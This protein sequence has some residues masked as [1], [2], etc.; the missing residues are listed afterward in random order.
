MPRHDH[1]CR[2]CRAE[3]EVTTAEPSACTVCGSTDTHWR[4]KLGNTG[5]FAAFWHPNLGHEPV[6]VD[7]AR[8][9][10]KEMEKA[11]VFIGESPRREKYQRLPQTRE[12]AQF[13]S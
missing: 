4:P 3:F 13:G 6:Y 10:D 12:E 7:S 9:L 11:Q 5:G 8:T 1:W 2:R